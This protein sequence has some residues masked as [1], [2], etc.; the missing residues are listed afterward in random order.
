M[1]S[2]SGPVSFSRD[3]HGQISVRRG[4]GGLVSGLSSVASHEDVLWVCAALSDADRAAAQT[5]P[6][7]MFGLDGTPGGSAVRMLDIPAATF[8]RAYNTVA[9]S[10]LWF[11]HHMLYDT[12]NQPQFGIA[13]RRDWD[14]YRDYNTAFAKALASAA[15]ELLD[16]R[17]VIQ[18]YHLALAP[19]M[20]AE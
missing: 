13:F 17:A 7:G 3:D 20:L 9:N 6:G 11:I 16:V 10:V 1:T 19:R 14:A 8:N 5:A 2:D 15:D 18:D 12:P 4:G